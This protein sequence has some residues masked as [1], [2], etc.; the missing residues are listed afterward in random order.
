MPSMSDWVSS[1][2]GKPG[3]EVEQGKNKML[4]LD[5]PR[6]HARRWSNIEV[7]VHESF[8]W[9]IEALPHMIH[10]TSVHA[11]DVTLAVHRIESSSSCV[12]CLLL[13]KIFRVSDRIALIW[14]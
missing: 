12:I 1:L 13:Y 6:H 2:A 8:S 7:I 11:G 5:R 14:G 9:P 10:F 4:C 3:V